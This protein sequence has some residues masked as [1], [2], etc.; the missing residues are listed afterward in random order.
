MIGGIIEGFGAL[1]VVRMGTPPQW[2]ASGEGRARA[3]AR[4]GWAVVGYGGEASTVTG[5]RRLLN[6][7]GLAGAREPQAFSSDHGLAS[8][9]W[10]TGY[11]TE[12]RKLAGSHGLCNPGTKLSAAMDSCV[13]SIC[14]AA[15]TC[16]SDAWSSACIALVGSVCGRDCSPHT[17]SIPTFDPDW[18]VAN[19]L[20]ADC[21]A[22]ANN[23]GGV[24]SL[25]PG[26]W[27]PVPAGTIGQ[28]GFA[29]QTDGLL[30]A[31]ATAPCPEN[32]MKVALRTNDTG[33]QHWLRQDADGGWS[34]K[35]AN[36][37]PTNHDDSE[38]EIDPEHSV[39]ED[40][41]IFGG[42]FCTCADS[43]QGRSRMITLPPPSE[44][45]NCGGDSWCV[46]GFPLLTANVGPDMF[47]ALP[48]RAALNATVTEDGVVNPPGLALAWSTTS[49]PGTVTFTPPDALN[50]TASFSA[51]GV[52]TLRLTADRG[53][54]I[55][56][57]FDEVEV[58][59]AGSPC[60]GLCASPV[61]FAING[62]YTASS[63]GE[64]TVCYETTSVIHGGNCGN[65]ASPR[66]LTV[67]GSSRA[68]NFQNWA[69]VPS[70]RNGGYCI[71]TTA[72]AHP[73]AYFS[74]W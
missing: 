65:F 67:N 6:G 55:P 21:Y 19:A 31:T 27:Y 26:G 72:G 12:A 61:K 8:G 45:P 24:G 63:I 50:T 53:L 57:T 3:S 41:P 11:Y 54:P 25:Q 16:C 56:T 52:Y 44:R 64:G 4:S 33:S 14:A 9:G 28:I 73:Y 22:Y 42:Y 59:V 70:A 49:G 18:W 36:G 29:A 43:Q 39:I 7:I 60:A 40:Y 20:D 51:P 2:S 15:P 69:S 13:A 58:T 5:T 17:C 32:R 23:L 46:G 37:V 66:I 35:F 74:V 38:H 10:T 30:P 68:C 47:I 1:E 71:Q 34:H 62:S 48:G